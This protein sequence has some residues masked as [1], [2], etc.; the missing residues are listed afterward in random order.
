MI[1]DLLKYRAYENVKLT[2]TIFSLYVAYNSLIINC[3]SRAMK[4]TALYTSAILPSTLLLTFK[5]GFL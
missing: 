1:S 2:K 4:T 5:T 3:K